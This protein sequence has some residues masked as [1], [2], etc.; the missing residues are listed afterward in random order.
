MFLFI[1]LFISGSKTLIEFS[2]FF[3]F[4]LTISAAT[5][6][7]SGHDL[8][9]GQAIVSLLV[10][11]LLPLPPKDLLN[12]AVCFLTSKTDSFLH[13]LNDLG[14]KTKLESPASLALLHS[15]LVFSCLWLCSSHAGL[16]AVL[17]THHMHSHLWFYESGLPLSQHPH[18]SFPQSS[19]VCSFLVSLP[20]WSCYSQ[21]FTL[22]LSLY[23]DLFHFPSDHLYCH[24]WNKDRSFSH[25]HHCP[26][27]R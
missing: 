6:K 27:D 11:G 20:C 5:L 15:Y 23:S 2:F 21:P 3:V 10:S 14:G 8:S 24:W 18:Y 4:F 25:S 7:P 26:K 9:C 12:I 13:L 1:L 22:P 16:P 17:R 19:E